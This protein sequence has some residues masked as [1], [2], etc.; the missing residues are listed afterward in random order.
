MFRNYI[1]IAW[2]NL[3]RH[4]FYAAVNIFGL[5]VGI[6]FTLL[7]SVYVWSQWQVNHQLR[8]ASQQYIIQSKWKDPNQG[9]PLATVG[10]LAKALKETY[11]GL[12]KNY[13][14]FDGVTSNVS[15]GDKHFRE[16]L[17]LGDSTLLTMYGFPL[18]HGNPQTALNQPFTA[19][20]TRDKALKYFGTTDV[21]G[22]NITIES[23]SGSKHDFM[24]TGVLDNIA[25]NSVTSLIDKYPGNFFVSTQNLAFFGRN[26]NWQN[27]FIASYIELQ[28][29]VQPKA[30]EQPIQKLMHD[31]A[32][33]TTVSDMQ[34]YLAPLTSFYL[35]ANNSLVRKMMYA[36]S[37]IALFILAMAIINFVN[38]SVSR[39]ATR[40]R[41]IGI[42]KVLG[43]LKRQLIMQ[44]LTESTVIVFIAACISVLLFY[45]FKSPFSTILGSTVAG[46]SIFP[47]YFVVF[48][49]LF[50]LLVGIIAG[51]YPALVLSALTSVISLKGKVMTAN[52]HVL[53]RKSL[54]IF[55]FAT[56]SIAFI[57]VFIISKQINFFLDTDLGYNK[58]YVLSA[59][60]PR[61][62]NRPGVDHMET[63]RNLF[64]TLPEVKD[65]TLSYEIP[66]GNSSGS[67]S[68]YRAGTDST[69]SIAAV[70]LTTDEH[71]LDVYKI[72]LYAGSFF[73][74]GGQDSAKV[75]LNETAARAL[76]YTNAS[77]AIGQLV[78]IPNDPTVFTVKGITRDFYFG[79]MQQRIAPIIFFN[80]QFAII[81]RYFSFKLRPGNLQRSIS[82]L[83]RQW[84]AVLPGSPF[85]YR[86]MDDA[87]ASMYQTELQLKKASYVATTLA[88]I[89]VLLGVVGLISLSIRKR[90]KEIGIRKVLGSSVPAILFLFIREF[91]WI[92]AIG[93]LIG[94]P[95][96]YLMMQKWLNT[97]AY[98]INITVQ[99]FAIALITLAAITAL[100]ICLQTVK[101]ALT[102]PV[103]S[104]RN[105]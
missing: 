16:N 86:F 38:M 64:A 62:W 68:L 18:L 76:G 37:V 41:E 102:N 65:V 5:S 101:A 105:E 75:I 28:K 45:L 15:K 84:S 31:N 97:Y 66:D 93:G 88:L 36:L 29:G 92:I 8:N 24:I 33:A 32:P 10:E 40:L 42:R 77:A 17:Q 25:H 96:A 9:F 80:V 87:L 12:V 79:S 81:Y 48:P 100:L 51:I 104:L 7:V 26:M 61:N 54:V 63:V 103:E 69:Q 11:P 2:R 58:D 56:A 44:F 72:P 60:V 34:P 13:Y 19:V 98:R 53:L 1:T 43:S 6:A 91:L 95:A 20:I 3:T 23:F 27:N 78:R 52:E 57:G 67:A 59:Q 74:G 71:Y 35:Q 39:S 50:V 73:G 22:Q 49:I 30:L 4:P 14:R 21:I 99:P 70:A 47:F 55:Q 85:E 90:T 82:S 94:C 46:L 89:I 83:Q